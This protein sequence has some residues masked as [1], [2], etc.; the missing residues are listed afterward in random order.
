MYGFG[1]LAI[2]WMINA[3]LLLIAGIEGVLYSASA[4]D[5]K[6]FK[7]TL[8]I[9]AAFSGLLLFGSIL[10]MNPDGIFHVYQEVIEP[11]P[12]E[13]Q[14]PIVDLNI[15]EILRHSKLSLFQGDVPS[16]AYYFC[17]VEIII[18]FVIT[19][20][21]IITHFAMDKNGVGPNSKV[22]EVANTTVIHPKSVRKVPTSESTRKDNAYAT[23]ST[24]AA[25]RYTPLTNQKAD[26]RPNPYL[27]MQ[28]P[29]GI[30]TQ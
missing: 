23:P 8:Y 20:I 19:S 15:L 18:L 12:D 2:F 26:R 27:G 14:E 10:M 3:A 25:S 30:I 5:H 13:E 24:P 4:G 28:N 21:K 7:I 17:A 11:E 16:G 29:I 1:I 22:P 6:W 9:N